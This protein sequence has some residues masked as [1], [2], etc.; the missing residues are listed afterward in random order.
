MKRNGGGSIVNVGS[1]W[2]HQAIK[3]T[4]L[5]RVLMAKAG[6]HALTQH[7]R[8]ASPLTRRF[9]STRSRPPWSARLS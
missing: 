8:W 4:P 2:A 1:M 7:L 3:A 5:L 6:L 9:A